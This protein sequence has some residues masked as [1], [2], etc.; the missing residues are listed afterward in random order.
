MEI[1]IGKWTQKT[2]WRHSLTIGG[3]MSCSMCSTLC[4]T[5]LT[6]K[7]ISF[8]HTSRCYEG[9]L[10]SWLSFAA[11]PLCLF[12]PSPTNG[13]FPMIIGGTEYDQSKNSPLGSQQYKIDPKTKSKSK[14]RIE[15]N[16]ENKSCST[17]QVDPK[18]ILTISP[19]SQGGGG[20]KDSQLM[21]FAIAHFLIA[22]IVRIFL[23]FPTL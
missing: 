12:G 7:I 16:L 23:T 5:R 8:M 22:T 9:I 18:T 2:Q 15:G 14:V 17:T 19:F 3:R 13:L 11:I 1:G 4:F 6:T 20:L 10:L 21:P